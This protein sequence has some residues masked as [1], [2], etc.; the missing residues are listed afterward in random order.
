MDEFQK[1]FSSAK[2]HRKDT[3]EQDARE[4]YKFCFN[5]REREWDESTGGDAEEIFADAVATIN[6]DFHGELFSTMTPENSQWVGFEAGVAI[7]EDKKDEAKKLIEDREKAI[8]K[9]LHASNYYSEGPTSFQDACVGN[10]CIWAERYHLNEAITFEAVP[11]SECYF[12]LGAH[13]LDDRFRRKKYFY[14]DLEQLFPDAQWPKELAD[15][16]K[17]SRGKA[18]VIWGFWR[19]YS[20]PGNPIWRQE[21][22]VDKK[23]VG[24]D[25]DLEGD[26]SCPMIVGRFNAQPN[27]AWGRGPGIRMLPTMRVYDEMVMMNLENMSRHNDYAYTYPHDGMLDLSDGIEDGIGYPAMPG[28][29]DQVR[30][31]GLEGNL[32]YGFFA[33]D[34]FKE[35]IMNGFYREIE[36]RGKTPPSASQY[37]GQEQKQI[38]RMARPSGKTWIEFGAGVLKRVE[39]LE[40]QPGGSL[41]EE[42]FLMLDDTTITLRPISPL[43]RAQ[44]R[45]EVLTSQ[46]IMGMAMEALGPEQAAMVIDGPTTMNAIKDKLNDELVK[47]RTQEEIQQI[48]QAQQPQPQGAPVEQPQG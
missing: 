39:F 36:Q 11:I 45:E 6:E 32:D 17:R 33:E 12:R 29:G 38:R 22:R 44:A 31:L 34:N 23:S 5:G 20:D 37:M 48:V 21:I 26:G 10:V 13:G 2:S 41:A 43:E 27:S 1:R 30:P 3:I 9:A 19:S 15:K 28:S 14:S 16:I 24:L 8:D 40:I 42:P 47:F 18:E 4:V 46:S 35:A 7:P 25:K